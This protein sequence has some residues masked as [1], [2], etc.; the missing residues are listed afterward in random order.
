MEGRDRPMVAEVWLAKLRQLQEAI[1]GRPMT[2][3]MWAPRHL[4]VVT[5]SRRIRDLFRKRY[6]IKCWECG[7]S[8]GP[9]SDRGLAKFDQAVIEERRVLDD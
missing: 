9:Y 4:P 8:G 7:L 5:Y 1:Y 3:C 2:E 6:W